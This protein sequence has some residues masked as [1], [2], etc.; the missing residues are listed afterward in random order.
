M[1]IPVYVVIRLLFHSQ[2]D[3][4]TKRHSADIVKICLHVNPY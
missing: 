2:S 4:V 3:I 1:G